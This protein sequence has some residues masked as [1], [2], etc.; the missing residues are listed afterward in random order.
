MLQERCNCYR[1]FMNW[2]YWCLRYSAFCYIK[3]YFYQLVYSYSF[4]NEQKKNCKIPAGKSNTLKVKIPSDLN[5]Y[6]F[7]YKETNKKYSSEIKKKSFSI[8]AKMSVRHIPF[9]YR[10]ISISC[11]LQMYCTLYIKDPILLDQK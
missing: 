3:I 9:Y 6:G 10:T 2:I 1:F 7:Q 4:R 8:Q 5:L 11:C